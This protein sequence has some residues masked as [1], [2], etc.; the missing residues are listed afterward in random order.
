MPSIDLCLP[1]HIIF[2]GGCP[3]GFGLGA[4][5]RGLISGM[6]EFALRSFDPRGLG[7]A[8]EGLTSGGLCAGLLFHEASVRGAYVRWLRSHH[9]C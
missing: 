8:T 9:R 3:G 4:Y 6:G 1:G 2:T 5:N 7:L